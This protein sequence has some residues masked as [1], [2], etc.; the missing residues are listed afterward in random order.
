MEGAVGILEK[1]LLHILEERQYFSLEDFNRNP[2][3]ELEK[4]NEHPFAK[5]EHN[6]NY[7]WE[8]ERKI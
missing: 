7:Y 3:E 6:R 4:L 2:W 1:G 5:K 8:A